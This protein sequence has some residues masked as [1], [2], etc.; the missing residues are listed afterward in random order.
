MKRFGFLNMGLIAMG[1]MVFS[2]TSCSDDP[3]PLPTV[4]FIATPNGYDVAITV[5][6]TNATTLAWTYG[7][8]STSAETTNHTHTYTK[9]GDYAIVVVATNESGTATK[10][11]NVTIAAS[12]TELL[13]GATASGKVWILDS[14]AGTSVQKIDK[15]LTLWTG[16]PAGA[17]DMFE[18]GAEYDNEYTFKPSGDYGVAGKNGAVL[19]GILYSII[20]ELDIIVPP[21]SGAAGLTGAAFTDATGKFVLHEGEDLTMSVTNEDYPNGTNEEGVTEVT[22]AKANFLTFS[23]GLH[24]GVRDFN[25][26]VLIKSLTP[27]KMDVTFFISSLNPEDYP[28]SL[29]KA[30]IAISTS[31]KL[32]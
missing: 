18:L 12:M 22:F 13:A 5:E 31:M 7:D 24:F 17:L 9:S 26:T 25:T 6:S 14:G 19:T 10:T 29:G 2:F 30:S 15:D 32:K 23:E 21:N 16:L 1:L 20:N 8:G 11:V 28:E 27:T 4:N 3:I